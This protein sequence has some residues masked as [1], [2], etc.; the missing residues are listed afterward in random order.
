MS[1][2]RAHT[3]SEA[4][5]LWLR[6]RMTDA[7][8]AEQVGV[9]RADTIRD[10]RREEHWEDQKREL[11]RLVDEEIRDRQ[12]KK[13]EALDVKYDQLGEAL[14]SLMVRL[15]R[16]RAPDGSPEASAAD[17]RS[18]A[19]ALLALQKV[20]RVALGA[21]NPLKVT[22]DVPPIQIVYQERGPNDPGTVR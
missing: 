21:D 15:M 2:Y 22:P 18:L 8:I 14:E 3:R 5:R 10:W 11:D 20:R 13:V 7:E 16:A 4:R 9:Q 17:V 19:G 1:E 12:R 6:G